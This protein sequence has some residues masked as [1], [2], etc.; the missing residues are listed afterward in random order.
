MKDNNGDGGILDAVDKIINIYQ[1]NKDMVEGVVPSGNSVNIDDQSP[2]REA[3]VAEDEVT[4][5][6]E[7]KG[8][9]FDNIRIDDTEKGILV[10][11]NGKTV[12]AEVPSDV[13]ID[14]AE[15]SLNNGVLEVKLPREGGEE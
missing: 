8:G 13:D 2:L 15:A 5:V 4:I 12:E 7:V 6:M 9:G 10:G 14:G 11:M 3:I 1:E